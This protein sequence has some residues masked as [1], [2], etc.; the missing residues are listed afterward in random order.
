[1]AGA[2]GA[3]DTIMA[4]TIHASRDSDFVQTLRLDPHAAAQKARAL[5]RAG[6]DVHVTD[7][8]GQRYWFDASDGL[9]PLKIDDPIW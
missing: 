1:M 5:L 9:V 4:F 2:A 6:W 3:E 8:A 7:Q